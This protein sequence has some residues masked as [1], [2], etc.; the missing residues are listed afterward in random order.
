VNNHTEQHYKDAAQQIQPDMLSK[1]FAAKAEAGFEQK[2]PKLVGLADEF[3]EHVREQAISARELE[4]K[5]LL[6]GDNMEGVKKRGANL[7]NDISDKQKQKLKKGKKTNDAFALLL[8]QIDD[9]TDRINDNLDSLKDKYGSDVIG[10][11]ADTY[12]TE[13]EQQGLITNDQKM[14]VLV[15]KM[16]DADG[17]IKPDF[18][19]IDPREIE[20]IE[21]WHKREGLKLEAQAMNREAALNG[22]TE[23]M[24]ENAADM[25]E[26]T[27]SE[28]SRTL[29]K[30]FENEDLKQAVE[31]TNKDMAENVY[32]GGF[33]IG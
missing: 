24:K 8:Q 32:E 25:T 14:K 30:S 33:T 2:A 13:E 29:Y 21:D 28:G 3:A 10:G 27:D 16:A 22:V 15:E 5:I 26:G 4:Q 12:L 20:V 18:E 19:N 23:Q 1:G 7:L 9:L 6:S 17:K 11:M 31:E